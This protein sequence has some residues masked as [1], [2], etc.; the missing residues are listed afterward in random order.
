MKKIKYTYLKI[1]VLLAFCVTVITSCDRSLSE[2]MEIATFGNTAEIFTDNFIGL[3][4]FFYFPFVPDGAKPD[5]FSVDNDVAYESTASIRIDVPNANDPS[6]GFAGANFTIDGAGRNLTE[7]DALTFWAKS[8]QA[9]TVGDIG[10]GEEFRAAMTDVDFTTNWKKYIIPIPDPAKLTE[11]RTVFGFSAGGIGDVPGQEVGYT[12]WI[13]ELKFENLG[14][15][16]Q[17]RPAV[18]DGLNQTIQTFIGANIPMSGLTQTYNLGD[19]SNQTVS[20]T[21]SYF[22]FKSSDP[23]IAQVS[24]LGIVS[25]LSEGTVIITATLAN[26]RAA[27]SLTIESL[28]EFQSAPLPP[29]RDLADVISI[30]SDAYTNVAVDYY[31]GFFAPFQTTLG[32]TGTGGADISVN[33]DGAINY[34]LLNFVA[35]GTFLDVPSVNATDMTHLHVDIQVRETIDAG[36]YI[37]LQLLN[38]VGE[39][40][41]SGTVKIEGTSLSANEWISLDVPL[42]DFGL[43]TRSQLGLLFFI[44][45][46]TISDILVDNIYYY[47]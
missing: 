19:G 43:A 41:T 11:I 6:G 25:V 47:R 13:D 4:T 9:A 37:N 32:G 18:Q 35:I 20:A 22:T 46:N 1:A 29:A 38:S 33:G 42:D 31:N 23:N 28:G 15:V 7:Y 14:T 44:S 5:V 45:D 34:T 36:D 12:F 10:F 27:G 8:S 17:P 40:E 39:G 30:F 24:E 3:G 2:D 16:A 26:V 21:P